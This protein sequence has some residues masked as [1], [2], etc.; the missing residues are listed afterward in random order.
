[1]KQ[2]KVVAPGFS[3]LELMFAIAIMG[4][5][6]AGVYVFYSSIQ[7][8]ANVRTTQQ[9]LSLVKTAIASYETDKDEYPSKLSD[10]TP[11]YLQKLPKDGWKHD[12]KYRIT[13]NSQRPYELYS[14]GPNGPGSSKDEHISAWK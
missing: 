10:L 13:P 9:N 2:C 7:N 6:T 4:A 3:F 8:S 1:M 5:M 11:L 12:F 14:Y